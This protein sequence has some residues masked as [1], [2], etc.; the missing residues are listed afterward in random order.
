MLPAVSCRSLPIQDQRTMTVGDRSCRGWPESGTTM[1]LRSGNG[2]AFGAALA[3]SVAGSVGVLGRTSRIFVRAESRGRRRSL[4]G[5]PLYSQL[6]DLWRRKL[7]V[8]AAL[9]LLMG[10]LWVWQGFQGWQNLRAFNLSL[11]WYK[12]LPSSTALESW[13]LGTH[14]VA[15]VAGRRIPVTW[16]TL[17]GDFGMDA[18]FVS[19]GQLHR[20]LTACFLHHNVFHILFNLG[21]LYTLAPL[22]VGC[23][24]AFLT[25]FILSGIAGNWAF[26]HYGTA[27]YAVGASGGLCGLMGFEL[28]SLLRNRRVREFKALLQ[29]VFGM[30]VMGAIVP[31]VANEAHLGGLLAGVLVSL[32]VSRR[33]GYRGALLPWPVVLGLLSLAPFGRRFLPC[34][35]RGLSIGIQYPGTLA[36]GLFL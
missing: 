35:F 18:T 28:V 10:L 14:P 25:T 8:S 1:P 22:E 9:A 24:G 20:L 7:F 21:F 34:L 3:L 13:M 26:L 6:R 5:I 2:G 29:S 17:Q 4:E 16:S 30:L 33:S 27:R 36:R 23:R 32:V 31:G 15:L 19:R 12:R 11:P